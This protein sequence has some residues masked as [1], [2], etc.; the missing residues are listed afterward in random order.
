[1]DLLIADLSETSLDV[2]GYEARVLKTSKSRPILRYATTCFDKEKN[3]LVRINRILPLRMYD[4]PAEKTPLHLFRVF[5][6]GSKEPPLQC[7]GLDV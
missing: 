1:M 7:F 2:R 4:Q 5:F 3:A 6:K